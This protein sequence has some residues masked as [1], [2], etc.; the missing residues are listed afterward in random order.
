MSAE[1]FDDF[2]RKFEQ[3]PSWPGATYNP[4][5][6]SNG[7]RDVEAELDVPVVFVAS[8]FEW[9][10]PNPVG[11][12]PA[13]AAAKAAA[14]TAAKN[15]KPRK[16]RNKRGNGASQEPWLCDPIAIEDMYLISAAIDVPPA[17][18]LDAALYYATRDG[19]AT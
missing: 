9:K 13:I 7:V 6:G 2:K 17:T 11:Q 12:D 18:C 3:A 5:K 15:A 1:D 10:L 8:E 4:I 16:V 14:K 19:L